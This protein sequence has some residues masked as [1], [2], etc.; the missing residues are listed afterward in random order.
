MSPQIT[1]PLKSNSGHVGDTV[2]YSLRTLFN[3]ATSLIRGSSRSCE[4]VSSD[5]DTIAISK[6]KRLTRTE[7][8]YFQELRLC[9]PGRP[10]MTT[11]GIERDLLENRRAGDVSH[12]VPH[13]NPVL[14]G[15]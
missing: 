14:E 3:L 4:P 2:P 9:L 6:M 15:L 1:T 7:R 5:A 8:S 13:R 12:R 10:E 11:I